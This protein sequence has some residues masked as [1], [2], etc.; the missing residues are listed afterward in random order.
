MLTESRG[1]LSWGISGAADIFSKGDTV[2]GRW[3]MMILLMTTMNMGNM[4]YG[5]TTID[6]NYR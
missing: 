6:D 4:G 1:N 3:D 2:D 5:M